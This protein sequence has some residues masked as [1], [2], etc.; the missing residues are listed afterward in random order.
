MSWK[1]KEDYVELLKEY[2]DVFAWAP[3]DLQGIPPDLEKHHIDLIDGAVSVRQR[4]YKL[5]PKYSFMVKEEID[6]LSEAG[7][8]YPVNNSK[9][10]SPIVAIPKKVG[11]DGKVKIQVYQDF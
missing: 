10:V 7:F 3:S 2:S 9:W 6:R 5:N 4:Q 8:I 11:A 1:E